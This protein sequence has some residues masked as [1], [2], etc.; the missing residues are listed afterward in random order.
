MSLVRALLHED[1]PNMFRIRGRSAGLIS[2][3][4]LAGTVRN[5][6]ISGFPASSDTCA[7]S[8]LR[9]SGARTSSSL[10]FWRPHSL[11]RNHLHS[12]P[13]FWWVLF[14][15]RGFPRSLARLSITV[16]ISANSPS[17]SSPFSFSP[18]TLFFSP[19]W[20][21]YNWDT[22]SSD[23][24]YCE[25]L[26]PLWVLRFFFQYTSTVHLP[27]LSPQPQGS[28]GLQS[29]QRN[30]TKSLTSLIQQV[31]TASLSF[32]SGGLLEIFPVLLPSRVINPV[33]PRFASAFSPKHQDP[34]FSLGAVKPS[35]CR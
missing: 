35:S 16:P 32:C 6:A 34:N 11:N 9:S 7:F 3:N 2:Q 14:E 29:S 28:P 21:L 20:F 4:F 31:E 10:F 25:V 26:P 27:V 19:F 8:F 5:Y 30:L 24:F 1:P 15:F 13:P 18:F 12:P 17:R 33:G 22:F 23:F